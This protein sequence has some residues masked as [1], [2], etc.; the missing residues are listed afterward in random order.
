MLQTGRKSH[1][2]KL[3]RVKTTYQRYMIYSLW[4]LAEEN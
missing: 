2:S 4:V 3:K 1:Q